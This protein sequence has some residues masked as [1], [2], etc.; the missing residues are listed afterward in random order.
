MPNNPVTGIPGGRG[1]ASVPR[2]EDKP[3]FLS[4]GYSACHW[5]HV[6]EH[7]SF[8]NDD[9]RRADER[10]LRLHQGRSRRA[11]RPRSDLHERRADD[12]R[13]RRL[14]DVGLPD[15]RPEAVLRRHLLAARARGW[16]CPASTRCLS[17]VADAWQNRRE[18]AL[19]QAEQLDRRICNDMPRARPSARRTSLEPLMRSRGRRWNGAFDHQHGGFGGAP[20]FPHPM[21]LRLLLRCLAAR[22]ATTQLLADGHAHARQDGRRRHLR[23]PRRRLPSLLGR[24]AL[25]GAALR[26]NALRQR[27]AGAVLSRGLSGDR[28]RRLRP[29]GAGDAATTCCAK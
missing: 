19:E 27:P 17:A 13:P 5:C 26:K 21:D 25:A 15:A 2:R 8:E 6:M 3:I 22:A 11:A 16:A 24:R 4:I 23:S 9:D 14:A 10:A 28:R 7:E 20:K 18:Q 12:D 1:A 29:R